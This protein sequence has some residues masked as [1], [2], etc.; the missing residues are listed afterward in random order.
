MAENSTFPPPITVNKQV[1]C[2]L[3]ECF[4][5]DLVFYAFHHKTVVHA[6]NAKGVLL[7][8]PKHTGS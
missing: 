4:L 3:L 7:M 8:K 2:I 5:V 6:D 1:V